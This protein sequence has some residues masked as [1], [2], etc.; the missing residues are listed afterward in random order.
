MSSNVCNVFWE[1]WNNKIFIQWWQTAPAIS[2]SNVALNTNPV[3][4]LK[5]ASPEDS[6]TPLTC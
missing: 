3:T 1:F 5:T 4:V 6:K 2:P